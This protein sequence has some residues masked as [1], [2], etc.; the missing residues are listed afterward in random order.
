VKSRAYARLVAAVGGCALLLLGCDAEPDP[1]GVPSPAPTGPYVSVAVDNHFHDIHAENDIKID[2]ERA[3]IVKNQG[4]N[5][6]NVTIAGTDISQDVKPGDELSFDPVGD[7]LEPG[8][9]DLICKYHD[10]VGMTGRFTVV[11]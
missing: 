2:A 1:I 3:F 8:T 4:R 10:N 5:L 11:E 7:F 6:H 9:Y